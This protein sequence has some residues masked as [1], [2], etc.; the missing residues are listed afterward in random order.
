MRTYVTPFPVLEAWTA[1]LDRLANDLTEAT[2]ISDADWVPAVELYETPDE[3]VLRALLPGIDRER[4]EIEV[5]RKSVKLAGQRP[6]VERD[7]DRFF[8][9]EFRYGPFERLVGLPVE[10]Q[11]DAARADYTDGVLVLTL[12]KTV[13]ERQK[14][15]K[16]NLNR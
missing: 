14:V 12:P 13:S 8:R 6:A 1:G 15:V 10:V 2:R 7:G 5:S 4:L 3:L 16:V 9:S 11:N